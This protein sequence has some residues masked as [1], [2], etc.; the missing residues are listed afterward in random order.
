MATWGFTV[1]GIE[2][3]TFPLACSERVRISTA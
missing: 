1:N 3:F 2:A